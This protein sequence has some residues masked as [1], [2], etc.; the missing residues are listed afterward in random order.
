MTKAR[1]IKAEAPAKGYRGG[2]VKEALLAD[3]KEVGEKG[4]TTKELTEK[5]GVGPVNVGVWLVT[6]GKKSGVQKIARGVFALK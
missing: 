6:T 3:I 4:A 2:G 5:L 1:Y